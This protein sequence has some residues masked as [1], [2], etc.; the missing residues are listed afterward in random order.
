MNFVQIA[1][2][3]REKHNIRGTYSYPRL[4]YRSV[5]PLS[6]TNKETYSPRLPF[7]PHG[8]GGRRPVIHFHSLPVTLE[9]HTH[10]VFTYHSLPLL[11]QMLPGLCSVSQSG[12]QKILHSF[13]TVPPKTDVLYQE[14]Q[15]LPRGCRQQKLTSGPCLWEMMSCL[16]A[17][18]AIISPW[19]ERQCGL[20]G[21]WGERPGGPLPSP[22]LSGCM[23]KPAWK[24][25]SSPTHLQER[26]LE[27]LG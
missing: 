20:T 24:S 7:S 9:K 25:I 4:I 2:L 11:H 21:G 27:L 15:V 17:T 23:F 18:C 6:Q 12:S 1:T 5:Y 26:I 8:W 3:C 16:V 10:S 14:H 19:G 22:G 13:P